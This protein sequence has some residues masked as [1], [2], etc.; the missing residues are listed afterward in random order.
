MNQTERIEQIRQYYQ[1]E[2]VDLGYRL[3][4]DLVRDTQNM[5]MY[6]QMIDI[7]DWKEKNNPS[8]EEVVEKTE[9]MLQQLSDYNIPVYKPD[10]S[11]LIARNITKKYNRSNF[12]LSPIDI[13][14]KAREVIGLVGENGNGKTTLLTI[15][16]QE[17]TRTTGELSY[18]FSK[19]YTN[20]YELRTRL[21]YVPQRTQRWYGSL[22]DNL[23]FVLASY[24]TPEE[25]IEPRMFMMIAR[26]GLWKYKDLNWDELSSGYKM[27]FELARTLLRNPEI[28]LLDEPL[29]NLDVLAQQVILEDLKHICASLSH[30]IALIFS[31]QQLYEVEKVSDRVVFLNHGKTLNKEE[32]E[33]HDEYVII[34]LDTEEDKKVLSSIFEP[35]GIKDIKFNGGIYVLYF[36]KETKQYEILKQLSDN[37]VSIINFRDITYSTRRYFI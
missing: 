35:L 16:A 13:D 32:S 28:L 3:L 33:L 8:D 9:P 31:S 27:R 26:L 2:D 22:Q 18:Q 5:S 11:V 20:H 6:Q 30:P 12:Q 24:H 37:Q 1:Q 15:L 29:A 17:I 36:P 19:P 14:L 7:T 34:E 23:K 21:A 25:E 10:E 4:L